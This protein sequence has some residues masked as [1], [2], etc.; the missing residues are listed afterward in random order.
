MKKNSI[1]GAVEGAV[2]S[3]LET[4]QKLD[5]LKLDLNDP[6]VNPH[7]LKLEDLQQ[8]TEHM[9]P[10]VLKHGRDLFGMAC[11]VLAVNGAMNHLGDIAR[12]HNCIRQIQQPMEALTGTFVSLFEEITKLRS[13]TPDMI[14][15]VQAEITRAEAM[16]GTP[17]LL[18]ADGVTRLH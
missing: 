7:K 18:A 17:I 9:W 4:Q 1:A 11:T 15:L 6:A 14:K 13:W 5:R 3:M 2:E 16:E 12:R 8:Y 10:V